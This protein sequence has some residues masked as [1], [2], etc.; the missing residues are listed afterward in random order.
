M[1]TDKPAD[2]NL[3]KL[4]NLLTDQGRII[5]AGWVSY[6]RLVIPASASATQIEETRRGF[7]AGAQ[8]LFGSIMSIL[9]PGAEPTEND[10]KRFDYIHAELE[11]F[12]QSFRIGVGSKEGGN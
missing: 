2:D 11:A 5:E 10:L 3:T 12:G 4:T 6:L 9:E 8:H 1:S 7:Y